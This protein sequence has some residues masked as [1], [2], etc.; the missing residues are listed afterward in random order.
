MSVRYYPSRRN[1]L[2]LD[3]VEEECIMKCESTTKHKYIVNKECLKLS[4]FKVMIYVHSLSLY[5]VYLQSDLSIKR[6]QTE[7]FQL[8]GVGSRVT[9]LVLS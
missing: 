8:H 1:T 2:L 5:T 4:S 9:V 3:G 7:R 6:L